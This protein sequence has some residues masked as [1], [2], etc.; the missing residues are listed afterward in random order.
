MFGNAPRA[1]WSKWMPPDGLNRIP[2]ATRA[3]LATPLDG[4]TVL[5]EAGIGAFFEPKL[6]DRYG[7][8]G[9][10]HV[11]LESL[12]EAGFGHEDIDVVVLSHLHFDHAGGL[13]SAWEEG[14]EPRLLF[15]NATFVVGREQWERARDPHPRDRASYI[16]GLTGMLEASGRLE[17]VDGASTPALG[18][19]V[20]FHWSHGHTP[21]MML[22]EVLGPD[23]R[24]S[25]HHGGVVFCAD[26]VPGLPWVH[27]PITMGYDRCAET[28][29]DEK[30]AFLE[31]KLARDVHLFFT[32]DP[33][34]ALARLGR[35]ERGRFVAAQTF[36]R[37][38]ARPLGATA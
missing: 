37:L 5:F 27:V 14:S 18:D 24:D 28:L 4:R 16:P 12:R 22:A 32:H 2:L 35:D 33:G 6:R 13:L 17:L 10:G 15:P 31:D 3:L 7:I 9:E 34:C 30:Q 29:I 26:L 21:G 8:G 23:V 25:A 38:Q 11:L 20:R 19:A 1:M 36:A